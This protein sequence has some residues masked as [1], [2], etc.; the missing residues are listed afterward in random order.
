VKTTSTISVQLLLVLCL[1]WPAAGWCAR[2]NVEQA[3]DALRI[4]VPLSGLGLTLYKHDGEGQGQFWKSLITTVAVTEG[5]KASVSEARPNGAC[6]DAFPSG[7]TSAAFDGAAFIQRRYGWKLGW[8]AYAA[9]TFVAYS[10]V[11]ADKH[12]VTDV[13]AGAAIGILSAYYFTKPYHNVEISPVA[14]D[15]TLGVAVRS[16]W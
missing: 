2:S 3:G 10:R 4:L 5:L 16:Q 14:G 13:T 12:D 9:A 8:P 6:C 15:H 7:H 1:L 11:N